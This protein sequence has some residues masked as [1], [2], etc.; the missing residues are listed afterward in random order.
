MKFTCVAS[1]HYRKT[2]DFFFWFHETICKHVVYVLH[3]YIIYTMITLLTNEILPNYY[4]SDV[5]TATRE[6]DSSTKIFI[7]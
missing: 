7:A 2:I 5:Y 3:K 4:I 6:I 1:H